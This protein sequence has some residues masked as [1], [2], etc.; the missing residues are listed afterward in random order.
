MQQQQ[1]QQQQL[2]QQ[3][4]QQHSPAMGV[5]Y[6]PINMQQQQALAMQQ[7]PSNS[8]NSGSGSFMVKPFAAQQ[9]P[10]G[11]AAAA[12]MPSPVQPHQQQAAY[13]LS[14]QALQPTMLMHGQPSPGAVAGLGLQQQAQLHAQQ[15]MSDMTMG[16]PMVN[17]SLQV[18]SSQFSVVSN[19][20]YNISAMS[21][22]SLSSAPVAAGLFHINITGAQSQVSAARQLITSLLSPGF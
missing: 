11:V 6:T 7:Q 1:M 17:L 18:T 3:Q 16:G 22:A 10:G 13:L 9:Q 15:P 12:G 20:L 14:Q 4:M 8:D 19:Q 21:G 5:M 2:Q